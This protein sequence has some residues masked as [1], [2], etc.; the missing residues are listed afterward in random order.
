[1]VKMCQD[2]NRD[3]SRS[4]IDCEAFKF[5]LAVCKADCSGEKKWDFFE[6]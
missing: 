6:C 2:D 4:R 1:M 5:P 3:V